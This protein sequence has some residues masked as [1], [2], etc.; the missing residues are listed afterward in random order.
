MTLQLEEFRDGPYHY[1]LLKIACGKR[2]CS[3][4][5]HGPY[6]YA[7]I[8]LRNGKVVRRYIGKERPVRVGEKTQLTIP[9]ET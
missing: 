3:R 4:C 8:H 2:N 1:K 6:W 5:P 7:F 9:G